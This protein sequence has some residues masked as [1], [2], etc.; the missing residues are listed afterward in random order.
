MS[1]TVQFGLVMAKV[2]MR[3]CGHRERVNE[4]EE[5]TRKIRE[6]K[7]QTD[8]DSRSKKTTNRL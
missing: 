6:K 2:C 7:S 5:K 3:G 4:R 1:T 8:E